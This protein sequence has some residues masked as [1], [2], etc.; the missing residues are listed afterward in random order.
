MPDS[1]AGKTDPIHYQDAT[2]LARLIRTRQLSSREIVQAH[3][4]R[5]EV[6]NPKINA[7]VTLM[8][9]SALEAADIADKAVANGVELGP[10]HGVPFTIKDSMDT[11]GVPSQRGSLLFA[12]Y[13]PDQDAT[14]VARFKAAGGIPLAKTNIPEFAAWMESDNRLTG[15][16]N[17][18]W[19]L[20]RTAGGSSGG[21]G[22][23]IGAGLS[24]IGIGSDLAISVR[25]PA[26][27]NGIA[28]LKAT[29]GRIP[30]TGHF[31][32]SL[33]RF[34]HVG[35]MARTIRD[36]ALGYAIL[37]GADGIDPY[38]IFARDAQPADP[39]ID[40]QPIRVGWVSDSAFG[41]VDPEITAAVA[42]A[43]ARLADLGCDVEEVRLPFME[44]TD[45][46][47]PF[48]TLWY[49]IVPE[50]QKYATGREAEL[51]AIGAGLMATPQ[52]SVVDFIAAEAKVEQLKTAF[53]GYFRRYEVLLCPVNPFT[54]PPHGLKE[55]TVNGT[56][57]SAY[58]ALKATSPFN[59]TGL[60][61]LS[62]PFAFSSEQL[63]IGIQLVSRWLDEATIL[64]LGALLERSGGLGNRHPD[65]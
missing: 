15:R 44:Q 19:K 11:A 35:P 40:G 14:T 6:V 3:L 65:I 30:Y 9:E 7:I 39:R 20:D 47:A 25:G 31:P 22:A 5:V 36:V 62:V 51:H 41:P 21:E 10:L 63:P 53:A 4:D 42:A 48:L 17:N 27:F 23:A 61:A 37:K 12:G 50:V 55:L 43:A 8:A 52:P 2:A 58:H 13:V 54:A 60:P 45:W 38:A 49:E 28:A 24:P 46:L 33:S 64:R 18:P 56:T 59:M 32:T 29:H 26:A 57:V 1:S 34:W 16:T